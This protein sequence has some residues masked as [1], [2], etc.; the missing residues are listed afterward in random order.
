MN[1]LEYK[2]FDIELIHNKKLK[3]TYIKVE[4]T[5]KIIIKSPTT[6]NSFLLNVLR[7]KEKWIS[8]QISDIEKSEVQAVNIEDE[9]L[10]FGDICSIDI[11]DAEFLRKKLNKVKTNTVDKI[12]SCYDDFYK[13]VS[14]D[15]LTQ[16]V[17]YFSQVMNLNYSELKY[18]KMK[19]RW[20]SC[21]SEGVVTLNTQ[22]IKL[23]KSLI[24]YVV[25]HELAHLTHMN[26]SREFHALVD[27]YLNNSNQLKKELRNI[28]LLV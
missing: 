23:K 15:Y 26:H 7:S 28:R 11:P 20:G 14:R 19:S 16:R 21:N 17:Q 24:D 22:L 2:N 3:H 8:K 10:L 9:V 18:R 12:D 13:K 6:A 25:V 27:K 5:K 4:H 1:K